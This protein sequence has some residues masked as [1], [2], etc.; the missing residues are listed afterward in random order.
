[1]LLDKFLINIGLDFV[2]PI[3]EIM[4][5][6][7]RA[8]KR[9]PRKREWRVLE[10]LDH[11]GHHDLF[12]YSPSAGL[13]QVKAEAKSPHEFL[14]IGTKLVRNVD[15]RIREVVGEGRP[16]PFG[17]MSIHPKRR[18]HVIIAAGVGKYSESTE[19]LKELLSSKQRELDIKLRHELERLCRREGLDIPYG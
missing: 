2:K 3:A 4:D 6:M 1:M 10:G 12:F 17:L 11:R 8:Y 16:V 7:R 19:R 5:E 14:G 13:W 9:D 18:D 15:E